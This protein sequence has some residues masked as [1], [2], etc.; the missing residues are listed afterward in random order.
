MRNTAVVAIA[1]A[2]LVPCA[3]AAPQ[4]PE[5]GKYLLSLAR[6]V[7]LAT[8]IEQYRVAT[9]TLPSSGE[10]RI[11]LE[12]LPFWEEQL[13]D[14]W[15]TPLEVVVDRARGTYAVVSAGADRA[16]SRD[17]LVVRDGKLSIS[18]AEWLR[19][20]GVDGETVLQPG[21]PDR[22]KDDAVGEALRRFA[23]ALR[24]SDSVKAASKESLVQ[25]RNERL[26]R[27]Y[28]RTGRPLEA[29]KLYDSARMNDSAAS[30]NI[31]IEVLEVSDGLTGEQRDALIGAESRLIGQYAAKYTGLPNTRKLLEIAMYRAAARDDHRGELRWKGWLAREEGTVDGLRQFARGVVVATDEGK[32]S[33]EGA[34]S[35]QWEAFEALEKAVAAGYQSGDGTFGMMLIDGLL[36]TE[37]DA[38]RLKRLE[39]LRAIFHAEADK[40]YEQ[41]KAKN[42]TKSR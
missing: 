28:R 13:V 22:G 29:L 32:V 3:Y 42:K 33:T 38:S 14:A 30:I 24:H 6:A 36:K 2:L 31:L 20:L 41:Y 8:A 16:Q 15:E 35:L 25:M 17:D 37:R 21:K 40:L 39:K 18:P 19:T 23:G 7:E 4:H 10:A 9:G 5:A 34:P 12:E 11:L 1:V 26:I 27:R